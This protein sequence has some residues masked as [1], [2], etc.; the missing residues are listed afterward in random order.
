[1]KKK[2]L[3][4]N[5]ENCSRRYQKDNIKV[6]KENIINNNIIE[7]EID[8]IEEKDILGKEDKDFINSFLNED[9]KEEKMMKYKKY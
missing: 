1:M 3:I 9:V 2:I 4:P 5:R 8:D 7:D 6:N